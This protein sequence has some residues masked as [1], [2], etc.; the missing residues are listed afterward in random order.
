M[1]RRSWCLSDS[2]S[3]REL[4]EA[5]LHFS[6]PSIALVEKDWY[7]VKALTAIAAADTTP[8]RLVF[9]GGTAL[10]RAHCLIRRMSE[11]IDLRIVAD[12][13]PPRTAYRRLRDAVT[14]ALL[15][16]GFRFDPTNPAHRA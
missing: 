14:G 16:A 3:L 10:S 1:G 4:S 11:D 9:G 2:P 13:T 15:G 5:Q 8:F 12:G 6:L 7:V